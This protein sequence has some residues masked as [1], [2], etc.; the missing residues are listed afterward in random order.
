MTKLKL[1]TLLLTVLGTW[2]TGNT[3]A[4][5]QDGNGVYQIGTA[6]D[7][8]EFAGIVNNGTTNAN[9]VLT[10]D[11]DLTGKTWTP[12]GQDQKD[13]EGHFNGQG[14]RIKNLIINNTYDNQALFGQAV[15]GAVI[16]N[17]IIDASCSIKGRSFPAGILGHVWGEG[18]IVRNCG[19]EA[20][21]TAVKDGNGDGGQNAAG[22]VG[23]SEKIVY[24]SNCYNT[25]SISG[26]R[27]CAGICAWMG[28]SES[29]ITYCFSSGTVNNGE[30]LYRYNSEYGGASYNYQISGYQGTGFSDN[31]L[32]SG[33]LA[34][35]INT[36]ANNTVWYQNIG[37]DSHPVPFQNGNNST[38]YLHNNSI[39][40][41]LNS[42]KYVDGYFKLSNATDLQLFAGMVNG[43]NLTVN[44]KLMDN[45]DFSSQTVMI[46]APGKAY[47][48]TFDGQEKTV[49][50][51]YSISTTGEDG[52]CG[53]FR[54]INGATIRNLCVSGNIA[55]SG[56]CAGGVVSGIWQS[57]VVENC[58]SY[59]T[60]TDKTTGD[61][62]HGGIVARVSDK[63]SD[64]GSITIRNCAFLGTINA[65]S[66]TGS[67]G[68][69]GWPD[70]A[71]DGQVKIENCLMGGTLLLVQ[72]N[73]DNDVIVR[74]SATVTN[75]YYSALQGLKNSK[76]ATEKSTTNNGE[77][78]YLLNGS[79]SSG[80]WHQNLGT[81]DFPLPFSDGHKAVY[82]HNNVYSNIQG[83]TDD[84][85]QIANADDLESFAALVRMG[86][87][88]IKA[89]FTDNINM[90]GHGSFHG[91]GTADNRFNG[92]IDGQK[93]IISNWQVTA[94]EK[95]GLVRIGGG[96]LILKNITIANSCSF[97]GTDCTAAFVA[98]LNGSGNVTLLNLGNEASVTGGKNASGILGC[99]YN[100][101]VIV[102]MKNCYNSGNIF[103]TEEGGALSGWLGSAAKVY[104]CYNTGDITNGAGLCRGN[105]SYTNENTFTTSTSTSGDNCWTA[106]YVKSG[107]AVADFQNGKVFAS[108]YAYNANSVD[109]SVWRWETEGTPHPVLYGNKIAMNEDCT[110][111]MK[112]GGPEY[113]V[114]MFRTV[115][116]GGWNTVC[117]PFYL[118]STQVSSYFGSGAKVAML[119]DTK[120]G[121]D[122]VL[123]FKSINDGISAGQAYLVYPSVGFTSKEITSVTIYAAEP[124]GITQAGFTFQGVYNPTELNSSTDRIVAGGNTIVKTTGGTLKGFRAFFRATGNNARA[125]RF[126][127][128]DDVTGI[129]TPEG[130]FIEDGPVY[131][132]GGQRVNKPQHGLYIQNGKKVVIK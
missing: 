108:L 78:C 123:H 24:I 88:T 39:Y 3:W 90:D 81:D 50:I 116:T 8:I 117:L 58:V 129:I 32:T 59:V 131:N 110:N 34:Y 125:T 13:Y 5:T 12:I 132:L 49:T 61:G 65:D 51:N 56:K 57:G 115:K 72:D 69:L 43:G 46:G 54:R 106:N 100:G 37:V 4:L 87:P 111:R 38:V 76:S 40:S 27:E 94:T 113:D 11:I 103:A 64:V 30:G 119:D 48:G 79:L 97:T 82:A 45:I 31:D 109:G 73:N 20:S 18:V 16:E 36:S 66:R 10:A 107:D 102:T 95:V 104:N 1:K 68:I 2:M 22:I 96:G 124:Q 9:A 80:V 99:N 55:T 92:E 130:E 26:D 114:T 93:H 71:T 44:G 47:K 127:I 41:N 6:D 74:N 33:K 70:N 85:Y 52:E 118:S 77:L 98:D 15:G 42:D 35:L 25:G 62:T 17:I 128:D 121:S 75:C 120:D 28:N 126:V 86:N 29:T 7:L 89:Q 122:D 91:I 60:I 14:H 53:L 21:I 23:C 67:G 84:Y 83:K 112:S 19:N 63:K 105:G 101:S